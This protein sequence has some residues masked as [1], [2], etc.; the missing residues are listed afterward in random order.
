[1]SFFHLSKGLVPDSSKQTGIKP[2]FILNQKQ[3]TLK[4]L[5]SDPRHDKSIAVQKTASNKT[6]KLDD[7]VDSVGFK[8]EETNPKNSMCSAILK[9][10]IPINKINTKTLKQRQKEI[11]M[12]SMCSTD[13]E[14]YKFIQHQKKRLHELKKLAE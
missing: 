13:A 1:M 5:L 12:L 7:S 14:E 4:N 2:N 11:K 6:N 9:E 10:Q 8:I 3:F